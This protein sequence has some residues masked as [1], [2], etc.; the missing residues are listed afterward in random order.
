LK[1]LISLIFIAS[2]LISIVSCQ[3]KQISNTL[4]NK[5]EVSVSFCIDILGVEE[6]IFTQP[7]LETLAKLT[8]SG[9]IKL[10]KQI[11]INKAE[12]IEKLS[13]CAQNS[14]LIIAGS[15]M[16]EEVVETSERFPDKFFIL[17]DFPAKGLNIASVVFREED[18][19][20]R[21]LTI[22]QNNSKTKNIGALFPGDPA[23]SLSI[24]LKNRIPF[25]HIEFVPLSS[26][27]NEIVEKIKSFKEEKIDFLYLVKCH[28]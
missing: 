24:V 5:Q 9:L 28:T 21:A 22:C 11:C 2:I 15:L 7:I 27:S 19:A 4:D 20:N 3:K 13:F 1:I 17:L 12:Y 10:N 14:D 6:P 26:K 18:M 23:D 8:K 16:T 25:S